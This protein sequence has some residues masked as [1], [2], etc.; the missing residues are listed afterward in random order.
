MKCPHC[1]YE[2]RGTV[3]DD[4][5]Y[6]VGSREHGEHFSIRTTEQPV[7]LNGGTFYIQPEITAERGFGFGRQKQDVYACASC[8]IL[9][10][11]RNN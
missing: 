1:N 10:I 6:V 3:T 8:G 4:G 5:D 7:N 9:F 2:D 11:A